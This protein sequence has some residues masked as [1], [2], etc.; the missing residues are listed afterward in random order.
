MI[1]RYTAGGQYSKPLLA[2]RDYLM[3]NFQTNGSPH[4][5]VLWKEH[6]NVT[7]TNVAPLKQDLEFESPEHFTAFLLRWS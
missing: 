4:L 5:F 6:F 7:I 1:V 2:A 3:E